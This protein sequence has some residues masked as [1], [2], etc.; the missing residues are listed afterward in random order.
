M[1]K[2]TTI[3]RLEYRAA[4][5][6]RAGRAAYDRGVKLDANA[7]HERPGMPMAMAWAEG[8]RAA[9][10]EAARGRSTSEICQRSPGG[11]DRG[12]AA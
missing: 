10:R 8:W 5:G 6:Q 11:N 1:T 12:P 7:F 9:E 4:W 3:A 2:A